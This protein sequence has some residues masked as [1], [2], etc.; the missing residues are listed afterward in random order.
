MAP[1]V[2]DMFGRSGFRDWMFGVVEV[3]EYLNA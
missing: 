2:L 3:Y 1:C